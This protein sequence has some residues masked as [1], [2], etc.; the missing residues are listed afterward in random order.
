MALMD[1][2]AAAGKRGLEVS[3]L[4]EHV[5]TR[6]DGLS[7]A[8]HHDEETIEIIR[9][10]CV[11]RT[12]LLFRDQTGLTPAGYLAFARR[13][14][15]RPDLH[16]LRHYC[17][18]EH[19][20]IFVVGNVHEKE[21][22]AGSPKVGL[23]WHTDHYHLPEPGLFTY[24][25][26]IEVPP[27][28]GDTRYA[29]GIAAYE[30]LPAGKRAAIDGLKVR[31]SRARLFRNLFPEATAEEMEA[32]R[33]R[34]P[35]VVHP[36]V[37]THPELGKRGLYLGGEWGSCIDGLESGRAQALYDE[38][39]QHM[40]QDRFCYRHRWQPGDVLMSD[41]RCSMHRASEWDESAYVRRLHRIIMID[42]QKPY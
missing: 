35:D 41:N 15:G 7:L 1:W 22:K 12:L 29:N 5:G 11:E 24:L 30:A 34:I 39:L 37:R 38:L 6:I 13:F 17:L 32:E 8:R 10:A 16:S 14:G 33:R 23:N 3:D 26:A 2:R 27:G 28:Q 20:E 9:A 19:H 4:A 42:S 25:H 21:A 40:I 31:H 18:A 36:L